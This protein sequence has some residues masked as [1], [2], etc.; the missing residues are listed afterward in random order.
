MRHLR[1]WI[2][3]WLE[4]KGDYYIPNFE[5][6]YS[7]TDT[8]CTVSCVSLQ[9]LYLEG[10]DLKCLPEN[11]FDCLANLKWLDLRNNYLTAMPSTYIGRHEN[12]RNLLLEGNQLRT[13]PL[14][15]G[16]HK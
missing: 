4:L 8:E 15:L 3:H 12:L 13:L 9:Y 1:P 6:F 7:V 14:E 5:H 16:T 2:R 11:F 10:N